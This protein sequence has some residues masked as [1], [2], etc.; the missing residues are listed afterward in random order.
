[1]KNLILNSTYR[2]IE[3][4]P[5]TNNCLNFIEL[6]GYVT[7]KSNNK[8]NKRPVIAV[9]CAC[10]K[11]LNVLLRNYLSGK[12]QSCGCTRRKFIT[13][14]KIARRTFTKAENKKY[15]AYLNRAKSKE[16]E[17]EFTKDEFINLINT[18]CIYCGVV[19]LNGLDRIDSSKGYTK[20][21]TQPCCGD[22]NIAKHTKS[23]EEYLDFIRRVH[24]HINMEDPQ[25]LQYANPL[26]EGYGIV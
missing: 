3:N 25:R 8:I 6:V 12:S 21:N 24:K 11:I 19:K 10:G 15:S 18:P 5:Q 9:K 14:V 7:E 4:I 2:I 16:F 17:F 20:S 13:A 1:M 26:I 22:C 23:H